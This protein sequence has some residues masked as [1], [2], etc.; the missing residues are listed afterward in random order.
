[1]GQSLTCSLFNR[2]EEGTG[3][4]FTCFPRIDLES[5][6]TKK[7]DPVMDPACL[8]KRLDEQIVVLLPSGSLGEFIHPEGD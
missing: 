4:P 3:D 8:I 2:D 6:T 5:N 1:M 7:R